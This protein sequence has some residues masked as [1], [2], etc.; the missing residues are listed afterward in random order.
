MAAGIER[1]FFRGSVH[2][3]LEYRYELLQ[4][5]GFESTVV[6]GDTNTS[7]GSLNFG[8][9][10]DTRDQIVRPRKGIA[11]H[12]VLELASEVIGSES[13]FQRVLIR[14]S[15]HR[16][17]KG[18]WL[19]CHFGLEGGA[20]SRLGSIQ[21]ELPTNKRFFPGGENSIRGYK[22]GE[23]S[24]LDEQGI[25]I[26]AEAYVLVHAELE[27]SILDSLAVVAFFDGLWSTPYLDQ[28]SMADTLTSAGLGIR[29]STPF[30]PLRL[31]YGHNLDPRPG[32]PDGT[33]HLTIG[34]PF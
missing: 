17:L 26:G 18:D 3:T 1:N 25:A 22:E 14:S 10:W 29:Y 19:R 13:N 6:P 34:F 24:P 7:A 15:Y 2:T 11:V 20:L 12:G 9:S 8:F 4:A 27:A 31:E 33:L 5:K 16:P 28:G 32:D 30:G 23:A 21:A